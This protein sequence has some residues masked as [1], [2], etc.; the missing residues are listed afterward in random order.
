MRVSNTHTHTHKHFTT[1]TF[2]LLVQRT[3]KLQRG[4]IVT[5]DNIACLL[6]ANDQ[7][8]KASPIQLLNVAFLPANV[9]IFTQTRYASSRRATEG[10][11][12]QRHMS[13]KRGLLVDCVM[14]REIAELDVLGGG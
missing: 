8:P 14:R 4:S 5:A 12:R 1:N 9:E 3:R 11:V 13:E 6:T 2:P 7:H 10:T